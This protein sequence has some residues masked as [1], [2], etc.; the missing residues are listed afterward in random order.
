MSERAK[1]R[2]LPL[3]R[4]DGRP[5]VI[6]PRAEATEQEPKA[7]LPPGARRRRVSPLAWAL[8]LPFVL[9]VLWFV[10]SLLVAA[11]AFLEAA[12]AGR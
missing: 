7:G 1:Y 11:A 12:V 6:P 5:R 2:P 4:E 3:N 9:V 10:L 8:L